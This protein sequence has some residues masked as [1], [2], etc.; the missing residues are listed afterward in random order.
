MTKKS[1]QDIEDYYVAKG[2]VGA[3]L[4]NTLQNDNEY[5]Q[6]L[7]D[8]KAKLNATFAITKAESS[9]YVLSTDEDYEILRLINLLRNLTL[10][11]TDQE[12]VRLISSQLELDWRKPILDKLHELTKKYG[13]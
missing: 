7:N 8:R 4:R 10:S 11:A 5:V 2:L 1:L 13:I 9:R 3:D 6:L 12:M